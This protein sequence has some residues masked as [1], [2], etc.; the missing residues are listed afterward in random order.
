MSFDVPVLFCIF[1]RPQQTERVFESIARQKPKHLLVVGDG[2][3]PDV[4]SDVEN[5]Y[6]A[7]SVI[8]RIDWDC[9][10]R[11]NFAK[12]NLGCRVRM[13]TGLSWAFQLAEEL[14][15]LEDDCLPDDSFFGYCRSLLDRY[16]DDPRVMM[17][18]GD[19][20][21]PCRRTESSYYFSRWTH[22]WGWASW[23]RAWQYFDVELKSW[24][25]LRKNL[26]FAK[27]FESLEEFQYWSGIFDGLAAGQIDTWDF[28]WMY[29]CWEQRGLAILP[30][31]N[32]VTNIG[33]GHGAT[34]TKD[35]E[36]RLANL[37]T[38]SL[39]FLVHPHE[40]RRN[41]EADRWTYENLFLPEIRRAASLSPV[42]R[43]WWQRLLSKRKSA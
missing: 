19:S 4:P 17:I 12:S 27:E 8:D 25:S 21:Q 35:A 11:C 42:K 39:E 26:E 36:S 24:E 32:L 20:F 30:E 2:P 22:I 15:I 3:R 9:N 14:I 33:F 23:R 10:V 41:K 28:A 7:R 37:P 18:S 43:T 40:V 13:A 29:A 16:R 34:H 31:S 5:V 1:N 38:Q 6:L